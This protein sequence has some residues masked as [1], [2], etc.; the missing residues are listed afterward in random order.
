LFTD[1]NHHT[2]YHKN[3][4]QLFAEVS[5]CAITNEWTPLVLELK[6]PYNDDTSIFKFRL[7]NGKASL[8]LPIGSFLLVLVPDLSGS[9][10]FDIRPYTSISD[11]NDGTFDILC[12]RYDQ[13]GVKETPETHFLFTK[14]NHSY[15]PAGRVSNYIHSRNVGD[16][17]MFKCND[18]K[19]PM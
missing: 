19:I 7:P 6:T 9:L 15:K 1:E 13:W 8:L 18:F 5:G 3:D 10:E 12:K 4:L 11:Q 16:V 14:T 2:I 17:V